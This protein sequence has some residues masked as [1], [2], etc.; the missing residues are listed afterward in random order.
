MLLVS[1][2]ASRFVS[3]RE[4]LERVGKRW[5]ENLIDES[6][7]QVLNF[8]APCGEDCPFELMQ[9]KSCYQDK[10]NRLIH[11]NL[12]AKV[13][14]RDKHVATVDA[15]TFFNRTTSD[16]CSYNYMGPKS[17][18]IDDHDDCI[19]PLEGIADASPNNVVLRPTNKKCDASGMTAQKYWRRTECFKYTLEETYDLVQVKTTGAENFIYCYLFNITVYGYEQPCPRYV[20]KLPSSTSF[21]IGNL[22]YKADDKRI[23]TELTLQP[24]WAHRINFQLMPHLHE[25]DPTET[26]NEIKED[27]GKIKD[28][29][30]LKPSVMNNLGTYWEAIF[31]PFVGCV[32]SILCCIWYFRRTRRVQP[33]LYDQ[34]DSVEEVIELQDTPVPKKPTAKMSKLALITCILL[35]GPAHAE[36]CQDEIFVIKFKYSDPCYSRINAIAEEDKQ[37]CS[38]HFDNV[39]IRPLRQICQGVPYTAA[40]DLMFLRNISPTNSS[41]RIRRATTG[42]YALAQMVAR[43]ETLERLTVKMVRQWKERKITADLLEIF[44]LNLTMDACSFKELKPQLC[45]LDI[46]CSEII[47]LM[48]P[49]RLA[50]DVSAYLAQLNITLL[51]MAIIV[52]G[53]FLLFVRYLKYKYRR[54]RQLNDRINTPYFRPPPCQMDLMAP[55]QYEAPSP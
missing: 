15:F 47:L 53:F 52:L 37:W 26:L 13:I 17:V 5:K 6:L 19:I 39:F 16:L 35:C 18:V 10:T 55:P 40:S 20:I 30:P 28:V 42:K 25:F 1:H 38:E 33:S 34:K 14:D 23:E 11:L 46:I 29:E 8:T 48:K 50:D 31:F 45:S 21:L 22:R 41:K 32:L 2:L 7:F 9:P 4:K 3:V 51:F 12:R 36:R 54:Y 43:F 49:S 44:G 27:L 24:E